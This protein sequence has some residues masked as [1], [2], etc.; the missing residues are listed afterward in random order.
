MGVKAGDE[1]IVPAL[2]VI[3]DPLVC[4]HM[5]ATPVFADVDPKTHNI[6]PKD[7]IKKIT[8]K[9]KAIIVVALH[10]LAVDMDPILQIAKKHNIKIIEDS[11]QTFL[12]KYKNKYSGTIGHIN[13]WSFEN[14]KHL[15]SG[16]EGGIIGTND[17]ELA[18]K[19]RKF[20]GIGYRHLTAE[21]GRTSLAL[22]VAQDPSYERFDTFGLNYRMP[23]ICA[24]VGL[25]QVE[26]IRE[27]VGRRQTIGKMFE[28]VV[29][30]CDWI[31]PQTIPEGFEHSYYT[32]AIRYYGDDK[33]GLS[34]REFYNLYKERGGDGFY[35]SCQIPYLEP[36]FKSFKI[37]GKSFKKGLCPIAESIQSRI[38]QFKTNYRDLDLANEKV[39]VLGNV[40]KS[41]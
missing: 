22:S 18:I 16:S 40:I 23:T 7:I 33:L 31:Q 1:V 27:I 37:N 17:E 35:G 13:V 15:S 11:C 38:M 5:R 8:S 29:S 32:F 34:W 3:M 21:A 6:D 28:D 30:G 10:G 20:C 41:I 9:T 14:T 12:G 26:R 2:T 25:A 19:A 4:I 39:Q 36:V 24:A